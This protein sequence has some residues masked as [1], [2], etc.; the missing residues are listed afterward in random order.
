MLRLGAAVLRLAVPGYPASTG[1]R[2][3]GVD[4]WKWAGVIDPV[5]VEGIARASSRFPKPHY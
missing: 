4:A 1:C 3:N 2:I 5:G